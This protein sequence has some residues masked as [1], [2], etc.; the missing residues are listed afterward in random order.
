[1]KINVTQYKRPNGARE[2]IS[3]EVS[4]D[5]GVLARQQVLSCE[6]VPGNKVALYGRLRTQEEEDEITLLADN[7]LDPN[8]PN[9]PQTKLIELI[10]AVSE[11][12]MIGEPT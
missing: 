3:V 1:M 5:V 6:I 7:C 8:D 12:A 10:K 2:V 4:D 11:S 9:S